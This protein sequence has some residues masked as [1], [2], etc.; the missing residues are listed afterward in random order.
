MFYVSLFHASLCCYIFYFL[1]QMLLGCA[2]MSSCMSSDVSNYVMSDV[3]QCVNIIV[4]KEISHYW[5][6]NKQRLITIFGRN[7]TNHSLALFM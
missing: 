2:L 5:G 4:R 1:W 6:N 7:L 3:C